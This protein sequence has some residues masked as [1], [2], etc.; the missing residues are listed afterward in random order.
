[1]EKRLPLG[2]EAF[3]EKTQSLSALKDYAKKLD[4]IHNIAE[5]LRK[6]TLDSYI[7]LTTNFSSQTQSTTRKS[8]TG[9]Q[10]PGSSSRRLDNGHKQRANSTEVPTPDEHQVPMQDSPTAANTETHNKTVENGFC[11]SN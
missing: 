9:R 4:G 2:D 6:T 3:K 7:F 5:R 11:K 8:Q 1:L 10:T